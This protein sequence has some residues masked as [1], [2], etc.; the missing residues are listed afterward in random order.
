MTN[1]SLNLVYNTNYPHPNLFNSNTDFQRPYTR[2]L[3]KDENFEKLLNDVKNRLRIETKDSKDRI[4]KS[5]R[6]WKEFVENI[7]DKIL[8]EVKI[9]GSLSIWNDIKRHRTVRQKVESIYH[10]VERCLKNWDENNFYIPQVES[11]EL[12]K[13]IIDVYKESLEFY[14]KMVENG[15]EKRDAI[16]IIPHGINLGIRIFLDGYHIFDPFGFIGIRACTNT[17]H[18]IV[19]IVNKIINN[20]KKDLPE[21]ENLLGPKCKL[22]FCPERNFCG[23]VK[24]FVRNYD[25]NLHLIFQ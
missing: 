19:K 18:E 21:I 11:P 1:A 24:K 15:I 9:K 6:I 25:E 2:I 12:K 8:L 10:A 7:Q 3:L 5:S 14:K 22:G 4:K 16:Y 23:L 13:E 20:L 17:D